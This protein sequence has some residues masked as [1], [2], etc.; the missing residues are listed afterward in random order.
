MFRPNL[1]VFLDLCGHTDTT[2]KL[3]VSDF[4]QQQVPL[5]ACG[6][7][8]ESGEIKLLVKCLLDSLGTV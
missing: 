8:Q 2:Q 4:C 3:K 7:D 5:K 6:Q 1:D